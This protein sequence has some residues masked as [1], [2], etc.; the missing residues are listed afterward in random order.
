[1]DYGSTRALAYAYDH[2]L[3]EIANL[4][5]TSGADTNITYNN[6]ETLFCKVI[7]K[8]DSAFAKK[9]ITAGV[10]VNKGS[11]HPLLLAYDNNLLDL[12]EAHLHASNAAIN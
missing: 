3:T 5:A 6:E 12:V 1:M 9:M 11:V 4:M 7:R 10:N 2:G 8:K